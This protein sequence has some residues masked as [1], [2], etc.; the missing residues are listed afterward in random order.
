MKTYSI[1]DKLSAKKDFER[2]LLAKEQVQSI[3]D[4]AKKGDP[5]AKKKVA[6]AIERTDDLLWVDDLKDAALELFG[7][8]PKVDE[9]EFHHRCALTV[10]SGKPDKEHLFNT[11]KSDAG[12]HI[13]NLEEPNRMSKDTVFFAKYLTFDFDSDASADEITRIIDNF[14][15]IRI[16]TRNYDIFRMKIKHIPGS[17]SLIPHRTGAN[18]GVADTVD[19]LH[20]TRGI[21]V[22]KFRRLLKF[23]GLSPFDLYLEI[24][25]TVATQLACD[26]EVTLRGW[27]G[28]MN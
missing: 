1:T 6:E 26:V 20:E 24:A 2:L 10:A 27:L 21:A 4:A 9:Q 8:Y 25:D 7:K 13:C 11:K 14:L 15:A 12:E 28:R 16:G 18:I 5:A 22:L 3:I 19:V 17:W 23:P